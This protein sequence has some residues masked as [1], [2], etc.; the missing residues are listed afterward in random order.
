[1]RKKRRKWKKG[2]VQGRTKRIKL[3]EK[4]HKRELTK[5]P[6]RRQRL[7]EAR[8]E[9]KKQLLVGPFRSFLK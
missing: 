3:A 8:I 5:E 7:I 1:M 9:Q 4:R 6:R 2:G